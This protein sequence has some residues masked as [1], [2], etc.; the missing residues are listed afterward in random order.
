MH[1]VECGPEDGPVVVFCHGFPESW[2][3]WRHQLRPLADAGYR[4]VALDMRG[5]GRSHK[6]LEVGSY[7]TLDHVG[8]VVGVLN[9]L[10]ASTAV[11]VGHDHGA[12][13]AWT[14]ATL[15]PDRFRAVVGLS[16]PLPP[17]PPVKPSGALQDLFGAEWFYTLWFHEPGVAEAVLDPN[18]ERFLRGFLYTLSGDCPGEPLRGLAGGV[19][20]DIFSRLTIPDELP[21]WL[22]AEDLAVYVGEFERSGF[23]GGLNWYR[24]LDRNWELAR[25]WDD[26]H[27]GQP[28]LFIAGERDCVLTMVAAG[29][30]HT[31]ANVPGLVDIVILPGCG[32]WT[33]QERPQHVNDLLLKFLHGLR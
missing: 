9:A 28:A 26:V 11:I 20:G 5:F 15:R 3:S 10:D 30:E 25:A 14:A 12:P 24:C 7:T 29:V 17:R 18:V 8:D 32:H 2:Y 33:Q 1:L 23:R 22:T 16:V 4:A 6:P 21:V 27:I 13:V 19:G 31:R